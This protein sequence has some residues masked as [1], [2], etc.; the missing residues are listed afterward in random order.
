LA[1]A[2][3]PPY[4]RRNKGWLPSL[5]IMRDDI[6]RGGKQ[7]LPALYEG[8]KDNLAEVLAEKSQAV[9]RA[10]RMRATFESARA[11]IIAARGGHVYNEAG[12]SLLYMEALARVMAHYVRGMFQYYRWQETGA[13]G[14]AVA[15][16]EELL[17]W[18]KAWDRYRNEIGKLEGIASL[19]RSL[20]SQ[21]ET[22][23][24]GAM[25]ATAEQALASLT[26]G[27]R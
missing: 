25:E 2:I 22:D 27:S 24:A 16:R 5:N 10:G 17:T 11:V 8:S 9:E 18:R 4:A 1:F 12:N 20:N 13:S 15:A 19:Y 14:M 7:I 21:K 23:S 3:S 6:I 26:D